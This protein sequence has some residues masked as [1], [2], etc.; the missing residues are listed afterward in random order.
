MLVHKEAAHRGLTEL[1]TV[2]TMHERKL[3]M[4]EAADAFVALPGGVGT[5]EEIFEVYTWTQL[6]FHRKP[7]A[8]LNVMGFYDSLF[9]FVHHVVA[10]GFLK[11][12]QLDS[13]FMETDMERL[14][15]RLEGYE[16][17]FDLWRSRSTENA[18]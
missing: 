5:L 14:L 11:A 15:E 9:A 1:H 8:F 17:S 18:S 12:E 13:L 10:Q 2:A 3:K 6:G 7:C 4:A 16:H